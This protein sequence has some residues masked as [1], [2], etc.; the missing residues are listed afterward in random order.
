MSYTDTYDVKYTGWEFE[1]AASPTPNFRFQ[2]HYSEPKGEK[3]N[4]GPNAVAYLNQHL[5]DWQ[6]AANGTSPA[7]TKLKSDLT[8]AQNRLKTASVSTITGHL[9]KSIFNVFATYSFT[10]NALKGLQIGA[11]A[12]SLGEQY[13]QPWDQVN[14]QRTL[15][16]GYT[17]YSALV[18]Y[19]R[20]FELMGRKVKARFQV[21]V[22]N[23]LNKDTLIFLNYQGYGSNLSQPMDYNLIAPRKFT[24]TASFSF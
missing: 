20:N 3:D 18:G 8:D 19:V 7:S 17:T 12:S 21:N 1:A 11:G 5:S 9:V 14:G 23:V 4:N 15:S 22:D 13:G 6:A 24:F 2:L 10:D 16:P